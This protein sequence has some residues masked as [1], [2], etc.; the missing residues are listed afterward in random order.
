MDILLRPKPDF[1]TEGVDLRLGLLEEKTRN[2]ELYI[3][4]QRN[5][6]KSD[7]SLIYANVGLTCLAMRWI[8]QVSILSSLGYDSGTHGNGRVI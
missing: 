4:Y 5:K 1:S 2:R 8:L 3:Y 7:V 6:K